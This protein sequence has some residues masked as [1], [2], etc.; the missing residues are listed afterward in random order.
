MKKVILGLAA[1]TLVA[2]EKDQQ[3]QEPKTGG[4]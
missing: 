2:C 1:I 3:L 4:G